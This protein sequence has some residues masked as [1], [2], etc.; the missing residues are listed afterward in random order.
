MNEKKENVLLTKSF[1]FAV[2]VVRLFQHL[3]ENK[4]EYVMSKEFLRSGRLGA[5]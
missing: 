3:N 2:R 4:K 5:L 1:A